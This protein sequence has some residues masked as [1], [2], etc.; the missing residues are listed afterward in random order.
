LV[1]GGVE[2]DL[3]LCKKGGKSFETSRRGRGL[4]AMAFEKARSQ[5]RRGDKESSAWWGE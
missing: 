2:C 5:L 3:H 1:L 4:K